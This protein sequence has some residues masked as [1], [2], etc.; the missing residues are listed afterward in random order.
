MEHLERASKTHKGKVSMGRSLEADPVAIRKWKQVNKA[1]ISVTA[2][3]FKLSQST[4][5]RYCADE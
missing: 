1:S 2:K 3:Q 4:I 5:K